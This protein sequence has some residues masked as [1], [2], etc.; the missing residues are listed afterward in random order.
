MRANMESLPVCRRLKA[1]VKAYGGT[2]VEA[3]TYCGIGSDHLH[4]VLKG[5]FPLKDD[6]RD[7]LERYLDQLEAKDGNGRGDDE[8]CCVKDRE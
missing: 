8:S 2:I 4:R 3:A 7:G 5:V 6:V 1:L